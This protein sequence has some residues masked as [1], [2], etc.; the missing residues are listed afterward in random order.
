LFEGLEIASFG[1]AFSEHVST[2]VPQQFMCKFLASVRLKDALV[3]T[4]LV[5][6]ST[7]R[8]SQVDDCQERIHVAHR[9]SVER[10]EPVSY[11]ETLAL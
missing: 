10:E 3:H 11:E 9:T 8:T 4:I 7:G 5:I 2:C 6:H 1:N